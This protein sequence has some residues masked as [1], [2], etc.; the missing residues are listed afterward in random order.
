MQRD[1]DLVRDLLKLAADSSEPHVDAYALSG[2][3]VS[4]DLIAYHVRIMTQAGLIESYVK[5]DGH[6]VPGACF[7]NSLTWQGNDFLDNVRSDTIWREV[8][9]K[10]ASSVGSV[11]FEVLSSL[12]SSVSLKLL[13]L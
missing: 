12:A 13:G 2:D 8:K 11:S 6:P 9:K 5:P 4:R 7:I 10:L 3:S 1:L